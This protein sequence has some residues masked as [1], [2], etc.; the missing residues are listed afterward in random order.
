MK[1]PPRVSPTKGVAKQSEVPGKALKQQ[2]TSPRKK[3]PENQHSHAPAASES[4]E[5]TQVPTKVKCCGVE[6]NADD[7]RARYEHR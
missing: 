4:T 5:L 6:L 2:R 7:K 1:T 3:A